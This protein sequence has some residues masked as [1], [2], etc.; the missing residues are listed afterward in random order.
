VIEVIDEPKVLVGVELVGMGS[1]I[2]VDPRP[3]RSVVDVR[4]IHAGLNANTFEADP[5]E[6]FTTNM[7]ACTGF[8]ALFMQV[9]G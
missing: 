4:P 1:S 7:E 8:N 3:E 6:P 5:A 9:I 2:P